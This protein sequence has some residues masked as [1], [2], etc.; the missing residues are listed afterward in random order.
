MFQT[1]KDSKSQR[2]SAGPAEEA[3]GHVL[4]A[5]CAASDAGSE[6][7]TRMGVDAVNLMT[8][9]ETPPDVPIGKVTPEIPLAQ[10][11][12]EDVLAAPA[13]KHSGEDET[14]KRIFADLDDIPVSEEIL[15][16]MEKELDKLREQAAA[17]SGESPTETER[18]GDE[19]QALRRA[20][21]IFDCNTNMPRQD[22]Q[23]S[24]HAGG[25][26]S[27]AIVQFLE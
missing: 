15:G 4:P 1:L 6:T 22:K 27:C 17:L 26:L 14:L 10:L 16:D 19:D 8:P 24:I 18:N 12:P 11:T 3:G 23:E 9:M 25:P 5:S 7:T 20:S 21:L 13:Q 2:R